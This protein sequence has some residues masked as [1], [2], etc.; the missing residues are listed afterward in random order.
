MNSIS[1]ISS[2]C[3][4][5]I[6][7]PL[8]TIILESDISSSCTVSSSGDDL[9]YVIEYNGKTDPNTYIPSNKGIG[10]LKCEIS[11][12][13]SINILAVGGGGGG[14]SNISSYTGGAWYRYC[15]GGGGGGAVM[16]NTFTL[17]NGT[18]TIS[19]E[20][21][22]GGSPYS[23]DTSNNSYYRGETGG[24]TKITFTTN[25]NYNR[26]IPG[27]GG[28]GGK[29]SLNGLDGGSGGGGGYNIY[30]GV[31]GN[32]GNTTVSGSTDM[33]GCSSN[34]DLNMNGYGRG[35]GGA[36]STNSKQN[37]GI[38]K[39]CTLPGFSDTWYFGAGGGGGAFSIDS[40]GYPS[41]GK[42]GIGGGGGGGV[43]IFDSFG[44]AI[45]TGG[46]NGGTNLNTG[47]NGERISG[48]VVD[49]GNA[50]PNSG[51]GGGGSVSYN[52]N[53]NKANGGYGA[54]GTVIITVKKSD[55]Y[56]IY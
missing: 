10:T 40:L 44:G 20:V 2:I 25:S 16:V 29:T 43:I 49:G 55:V 6:Y 30:Q 1:S 46:T 50:A 28:G 37:A 34:N 42:G 19:I 35:G 11:F 45:G 5:N 53:N 13:I 33:S 47:K 7:K 14:S 4:N 51:S 41:G 52:S 48:G 31:K 26:T 39:T 9:Y 22:L 3:Q 12:D 15:G 54:N 24:D 18:E 27:G 56:I 32:G 23:I 38:G 8:N 17:S 21:G 36:K